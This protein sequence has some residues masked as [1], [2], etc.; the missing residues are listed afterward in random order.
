MITGRELLHFS[1]L[2]RW[3]KNNIIDVKSLPHWHC[4]CLVVYVKTLITLISPPN[5]DWSFQLRVVVGGQ[6]SVLINRTWPQPETEL[7]I[8]P[9]LFSSSPPN[10]QTTEESPGENAGIVGHCSAENKIQS[11]KQFVRSL[12]QIRLHP[13]LPMENIRISF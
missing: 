10:F 6:S 8:I 7:K 12:L 9:T 13:S 11:E 1:L 4:F 3:R 5:I 2:R